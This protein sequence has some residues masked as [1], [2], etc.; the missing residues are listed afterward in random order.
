MRGIL[1]A[2]HLQCASLPLY[3]EV[4][5]AM[6]FM[7]ALFPAFDNPIQNYLVS[8]LY[9]APFTSY[10]DLDKPTS[11]SD[12]YSVQRGVLYPD[13]LLTASHLPLI[14]LPSRQQLT[15]LCLCT[16]DRVYFGRGGYRPSPC[17]RISTLQLYGTRRSD[18]SYCSL[19]LHRGRCGVAS[20]DVSG[21]C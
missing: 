14:A 13:G 15:Q 17:T 12:V 6:L 8:G 3:S 1:T 5:A 16:R 2:F 18:S 20:V 21:S 7:L 11:P 19:H 10:L 4:F 9:S